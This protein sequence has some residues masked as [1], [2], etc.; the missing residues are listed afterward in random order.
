METRK[1]AVSFI[2]YDKKFLIIQRL[3]SQY[4]G[5]LW[6]LVGG[7]IEKGEPP[8]AAVVREIMEEVGLVISLDKLESLGECIVKIDGDVWQTYTFRV[9][10]ICMPVIS[11]NKKEFQGYAWVTADECYHMQNLHKGVYQILEQMNMVNP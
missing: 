11:E 3:P 10:L 9:K 6:G 2:E 8:E 4:Q 7:K 1:A 5:N